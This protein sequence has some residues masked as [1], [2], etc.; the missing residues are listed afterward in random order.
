MSVLD[1]LK[2]TL[3]KKILSDLKTVQT[4]LKTH[5]HNYLPLTGGTVT[6]E[7]TFNDVVYA[8][9]IH[10]EIFTGKNNYNSALTLGINAYIESDIYKILLSG[11]ETAPQFR[12]TE[13]DILSIGSPSYKWK[14]IYATNG[15][16][17]TSDRNLKKNFADFDER[18]EKFFMK[19]LPQTFQFVDGDSGRTHFG[20]VSQDVEAALDECGLSDLDFAGF[21]K[22][23][24]TKPIYKDVT[25]EK[26]G[27]TKKEYIGEEAVLDESGNPV[28][29]YSLRY[30]EFIALNTHMIQKLYKDK[31]TLNER[32]T[33]IEEKLAN[34]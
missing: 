6:G 17:Q 19:L 26:T 31:Q 24:K 1:N 15:T 12:C 3:I 23:I 16:I 8:S 21:C 29:I 13:N 14:N 9:E 4:Q 22:D 32:V 11:S 34:L 25:D 33:V 30:D 2:D 7:T 18:H 10:S 27:E 5:T 20:F 28:Y